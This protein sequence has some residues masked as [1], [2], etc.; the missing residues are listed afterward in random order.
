[1]S[2]TERMRYVA[3]LLDEDRIA[4]EIEDALPVIMRPLPM[5]TDEQRAAVDDTA[6]LLA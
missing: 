5:I 6:G 2:H 3:A 4:H 1:M